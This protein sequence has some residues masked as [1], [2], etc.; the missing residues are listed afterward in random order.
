MSWVFDN[1]ELIRERTFEHV[2]IAIP[3]I[4]LSLLIAVPIGWFANRFRT[5]GGLLLGVLGLLYAVPSLPLF[6][7]LPGLLGT[8]LR[9][10]INVVAALT[11]YGV[12]LMVKVC[13]DG[14]GSLDRDVVQAGTALGF[15]PAARFWRVDLP[16]AGAV[17]LANLRIVAVST[18]SLT[19][20]GAVLGIK[21]LG[22]MFTDGLQRNIPEEIAVGIALTIA[23][24]FL[25]DGVIVVAG[26]RLMP[27][28]EVRK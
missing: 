4:L 10:P 26:K 27:W 18:V 23:L 28:S 16:L 21:S 12:A 15:S 25:L 11:I 8:G 17:I 3:P 22:L 6:I 19:T 7:V 20:V 1:L 2:R 5:T 14:F 24:A 13:A 9:D